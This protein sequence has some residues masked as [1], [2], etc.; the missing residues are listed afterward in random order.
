M[1][2]TVARDLPAIELDLEVIARALRNLLANAARYAPPA[3]EVEIEAGVAGADA[4]WIEVR[5]RGP[6]VP[7]DE[8]ATIFEP[9]QR[10]HHGERVNGGSGLGLAL[11]A[12]AATLH[13]GRVE[14][15]GRLDGDGACFRLTLP[16]RAAASRRRAS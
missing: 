4:L 15:R 1:R 8:R 7:V 16:L 12:R 2:I 6:G 3:S 13:G 5:D 10:G 9:F 14:V 11:V